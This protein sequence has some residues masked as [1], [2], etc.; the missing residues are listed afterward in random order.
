MLIRNGLVH[1][2][3]AFIGRRD[4]HLDSGR[5]EGIVEC[6]AAHSDD[7]VL[8]ATGCVVAPGFID[9]HNMCFKFDELDGN[10]G[11]NL[12]AQGIT[13]CLVGNCGQSGLLRA[14]TDFHTRIE[15]LGATRLGL[16]VAMLVGHNSL[17]SLVVKGSSKP[18]SKS[19]IETMARILGEALRSGAAGFST[20][21][22]YAPGRFAARGELERLVGVVGEANKLY[23]SHIRDEGPR[24]EESVL[25]AL[26]TA[27]AGKARL[28]ISHLKATGWR[29]WGKTREIAQL[30]DARRTDQEIF[31]TYYPYS[32]TS[33]VLRIVL[34]PAIDEHTGGDLSKLEYR[35][36][37]AAWIAEEGLHNL[38]RNGWNDVVIVSSEV[39]EVVG[40]SIGELAGCGSGYR[41]VI[42]LLRRD[43]NSRA[44]FHN[45]I[46]EEEVWDLSRLDYAMVCSDAY[47]YPSGSRMATHP[48]NYGAFARMLSHYADDGLE[49]FLRKITSLPAEVLGLPDRGR[50]AAGCPADVV[51]FEPE[52][53]VDHATY[54]VPCRIA[55]GI[56]A[57][58]VNG[59]VVFRE[60]EA[61]TVLP[62][63]FVS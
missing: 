14:E 37:D 63:Q 44:V 42:D 25:E 33:T 3:H 48:R 17:R 6:G 10:D 15:Q 27:R 59:Q 57:T 58:L 54:E 56:R 36:D 40:R 53:V 60:G 34:P 7:D 30:I 21:L 55:S 45:I 8:E 38:C 49:Y 2:G 22:M 47:V 28:V 43:P 23:T 4:V 39:G 13:T 12:T 19:E 52:N 18:A 32:A 62:G 51:V 5:I 11:V 9:L 31:V 46:S 1:D 24:L 16:N 50:L 41:A 61:T 20:G 35:E 29:Y 26:D